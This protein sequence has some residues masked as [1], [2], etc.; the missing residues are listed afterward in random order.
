MELPFVSVII[1]V[2]NDRASLQKCLSALYFQT[3]PYSRYEVLVVDNNSTEDLYSL[4]QQFPNVRYCQESILGSYAA[5]NKGVSVA[6]G[7]VIAFTDADCIPAA[8]WVSE[9][10]KA[11]LQHPEAGIIGGAVKF[12]FQS[13]KP[14]PVEYFDSIFY[15]QQQAYIERDHYAV[16]ANLFTRRLV[17]EKVGGFE[18]RLL[19]LGDQEWGQRVFAAGWDVV[20]CPSAIIQHPAR[21]TLEALLVK[22][23]RQARANVRLSQLCRKKA[24]TFSFMPMGWEFWRSVWRNR[25]LPTWQEKVSFAC[26]VH[27]FKW[28]IALVLAGQQR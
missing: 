14:N 17:L 28:A 9:G 22:G 1:P 4:C 15:L 20:Y 23:R 13:S 11:L 10:V 5:R 19:N 2:H 8:N 6:S 26:V 21:S 3:Y 12:C 25:N 7:E 27:R 24:P 16:S 18:A